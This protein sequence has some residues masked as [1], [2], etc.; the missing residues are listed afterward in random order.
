M[1][2]KIV[3]PDTILFEGEA[4]LAQLPGTGGLFEIMEKHAPIIAALQ[5]GTIRLTTAEG[6][7]RFEIK[8]GAVKGQQDDILIIAQ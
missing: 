3:K 7:K 6:E 4:T 5:A 2:V 1:K 8:A